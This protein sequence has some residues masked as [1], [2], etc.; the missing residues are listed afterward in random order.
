MS[1]D[2]LR[3][4]PGSREGRGERQTESLPKGRGVPR[5]AGKGLVLRVG[6]AI[7]VPGPQFPTGGPAGGGLGFPK[8]RVRGGAGEA[9]KGSESSRPELGAGRAVPAGSGPVWGGGPG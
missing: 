3:D 7:E 9:G 2:L 1:L 8:F 4:E 5:G 6:G